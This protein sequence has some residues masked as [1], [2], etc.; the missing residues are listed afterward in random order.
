MC[1]RYIEKRFFSWT[2]IT[3]TI[4]TWHPAQKPCNHF[5]QVQWLWIWISHHHEWTLNREW[6]YW[7]YWW[8]RVYTLAEKTAHST[9]QVQPLRIP[10]GK[11]SMSLRICLWDFFI[12]FVVKTLLSK[13]LCSDRD[14]CTLS[15]TF[16]NIQKVFLPIRWIWLLS[17]QKKTLAISLLSY[18]NKSK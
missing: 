1:N 4:S 7:W 16:A 11:H 5:F 15:E 14:Y 17:Y 8:P 3:L 10:N 2:Q 9:P 13:N 18:T 6:F 12:P